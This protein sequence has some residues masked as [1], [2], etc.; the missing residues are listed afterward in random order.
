MILDAIYYR[1]H[2][3]HPDTKFISIQFIKI[4]FAKT[5]ILW[6]AVLLAFEG[7]GTYVQFPIFYSWLA[8]PAFFHL[9]HESVWWELYS[10][11]LPLAF[12]AISTVLA[13]VLWFRESSRKIIIYNSIIVHFVGAAVC[14]FYVEQ[15]G[16]PLSNSVAMK[17]FVGVVSLIVSYYFWRMF[18]KIAMHKKQKEVLLQE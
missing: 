8:L 5:A 3:I 7:H 6:L 17:V 1:V 14:I 13:L 18:F 15:D 11:A 2:H 4:F 10:Y 16:P 12:F 9:S